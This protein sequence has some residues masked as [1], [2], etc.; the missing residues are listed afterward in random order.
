MGG[1]CYK[2]LFAVQ[3]IMVVKKRKEIDEKL[4]NSNPVKFL[5]CSYMFFLYFTKKKNLKIVN[6]HGWHIRSAVM[7]LW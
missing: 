5:F 1:L 4:I 3:W 7:C 2:T 6:A